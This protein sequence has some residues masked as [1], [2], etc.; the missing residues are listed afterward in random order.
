MPRR[1][2]HWGWGYE[3]EQPSDEELR[4]A[5]AFLAQRLG[6]GSSEPAQPVPLSEVSLPAPRL[7][8]PASLAEIC[9]TD[10]YERALHAYGRSYRDVVR[11]FGGRFDHPPDVVVRPRSEQELAAALEWALAAGAAVIPFGGG[12]S[13]V[14]G[15]EGRIDG[16]EFAGRGDDRRQGARPR[17]RDRPR[18]AVGAHP[19]RRDGTGLR[20]AARRARPHPA[21]LPAVV[22]VLDARGVDRD[23]RRWALR[24]ALHAHRRPRR[25]RAGAHAERGVGVA[26]AAGLRAPASPQTG[27]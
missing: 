11:A 6:F 24:D 3:D 27:C 1:L 2:K 19:G 8:P 15:V 5:C 12:T 4:G 9:F 23:P 20:G 14:G 26:P 22:S 16:G 10:T 18:V 17:A 7:A 25:V 13:V 21:P